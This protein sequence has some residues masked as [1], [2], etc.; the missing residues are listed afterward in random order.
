MCMVCSDKEEREISAWL[1]SP[2]TVT[3]E[4]SMSWP[5]KG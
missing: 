4:T 1:T 3:S 5:W 2:Y